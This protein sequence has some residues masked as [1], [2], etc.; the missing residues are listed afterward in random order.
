MEIWL[1]FTGHVKLS[2]KDNALCLGWGTAYR[3]C[4]L[5]KLDQRGQ[6]R[7]MIFTGCKS[8]QEFL[9]SKKSYSWPRHGKL[10]TLLLPCLRRWF[11]TDTQDSKFM[12]MQEPTWSGKLKCLPCKLQEEIKS[13]IDFFNS[14]KS[15]GKVTGCCLLT[16]V[17]LRRLL[18][19][20]QNIIQVVCVSWQKSLWGKARLRK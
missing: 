14:F 9:S 1:F 5:I 6:L 7:V 19:H 2:R 11:G 10:D 3:G 20:T 15:C 12:F 17:L 13:Y 16:S 8:I 4:V 18:S